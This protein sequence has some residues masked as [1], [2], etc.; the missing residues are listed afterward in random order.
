[1]LVSFHSLS[2]MRRNSFVCIFIM[3]RHCAVPLLSFCYLQ[4]IFPTADR[5][6]YHCLEQLFVMS[7]N[8]DVRNCIDQ[9]YSNR[10]KLCECYCDDPRNTD[11]AWLE[12]VAYIYHDYDNTFSHTIDEVIACSAC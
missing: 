8:V 5:A 12:I 3:Q 4:V 11:N 10:E 9:L 2:E 7:F 6:M 1:M